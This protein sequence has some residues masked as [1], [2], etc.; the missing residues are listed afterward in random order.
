MKP[1]SRGTW[2]FLPS[3]VMMMLLAA[4]VGCNKTADAKEETS[5][6]TSAKTA[7][8]D[9]A[10]VDKVVVYYFHNT[11]RCPTC[12]GIQKGIEEVIN[13]KFSKDIDAGMLEFHEL[14]MED[15]SN[16]KYVQQYQLSFSTMIVAAEAK[17]N[18]LKW[19]N[20]QK[21]WD[22]AHSPDELKAYVEKVIQQQ[23]DLIGRNV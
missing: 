6:E 7:A 5:V 13:G 23:L 8:S 11:R 19:E 14:N 15:E 3:L 22:I 12:M 2:S 20:A 17:G 10:R 9:A 1:F 18:T 16:K 21:V 4:I